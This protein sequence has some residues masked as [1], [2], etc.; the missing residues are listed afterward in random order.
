[1]TL[2][3][4][5]IRRVLLLGA[6]AL[7]TLAV[8]TRVAAAQ[9]PSP[10]LLIACEG[11]H[12]L[13]IADP[14][15]MKVVGRVPTRDMPFQVAVSDDGKLAFV[16]TGLQGK[17]DNPDSSQLRPPNHD[18]ISVID[19]GAQK[20]LRRVQTGL[21]STPQDIVFAGGKVYFTAGGYQAIG[22]LDP[23]S[24]EIDWMMGTGQGHTNLLVITK[25]LKKIFTV[26]TSSNSVSAITPWDTPGAYAPPLWKVTTIPVG[27]APEGIGMSPDEN[28]VWAVTK[29]D[30]GVSIIDTATKKVKQTLNLKAAVPLRLKF[31]PDGKWVLIATEFDGVVLVLDA[32]TRKEVKRITVVKQTEDFKVVNDKDSHAV[33]NGHPMMPKTVLRELLMAPD[34]LR[35]YV[36]VMGSNRVAIIDLKN[37]EVTGS[38]YRKA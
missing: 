24:N 25:D 37:L 3:E 23:A 28:E 18:Y 6:F 11:E 9:T 27:D 29:R 10:A 22:R 1:M 8:I 5:L 30:G 4:T 35:A 17:G 21:G 19:L 38:I 16:T 33:Q 14:V 31:T 15:T 32:V 34:G 20:E 36:G 26:N 12:A 13:D 2:Q 7:G